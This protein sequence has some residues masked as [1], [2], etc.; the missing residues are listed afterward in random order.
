MARSAASAT[1]SHLIPFGVRSLSFCLRAA[2]PAQNPMM[3]FQKFL[4]Y[5]TA[6]FVGPLRLAAALSTRGDQLRPNGIIDD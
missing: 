2:T 6:V 5:A 4:A 3:F 1:D